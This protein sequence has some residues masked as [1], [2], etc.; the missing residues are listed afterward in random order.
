MLALASAATL[1]GEVQARLERYVSAGGRL[2]LNGVLPSR[3]HDG[4]PCTVLADALGITVTGRVEAGLHYYPS[5]VPHGWAVEAGTRA[6][7]EERTGY[8]QLLSAPEGQPVL[9]EVGSGQPCAVEV[10][11]GDGRAVVI[12][13]DYPCDLDFWRAALAALDVRR[14]WVT[15]ADAPGLVVTPTANAHGEQLLHLVHVGPTPVS[16]TLAKDGAAFLDGR[17]LTMPPRSVLT[18]PVGVRVAGGRLLSSTTELLAR[19]AGEITLRRSQDAD[20]VVLETD[21][22]VSTDHGTVAREGQRVVVTL[23]QGRGEPAPA[24]IRIT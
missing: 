21:C 11:H 3:D 1:S 5:V 6:A 7:R 19:T 4:N 16:F 20:L 8:A 22:E 13:C 2:L 23:D 14:Q 9:T 24:R 17:S 18:L 15:Q 10:G 12:A